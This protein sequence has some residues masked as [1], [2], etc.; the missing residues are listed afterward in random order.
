[1]SEDCSTCPMCCLVDWLDDLLDEKTAELWR[2]INEEIRVC[3]LF[4]F[5]IPISTWKN[6]KFTK[7]RMFDLPLY[8]KRNKVRDIGVSYNR[9]IKAWVIDIELSGF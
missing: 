4:K 7:K 5:H 1:M 2:C 9:T 6:N 8:L 3:N